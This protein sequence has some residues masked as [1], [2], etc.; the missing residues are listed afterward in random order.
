MTNKS[1]SKPRKPN[2]ASGIISRGEIKY[3]N[4]A[5]K[6]RNIRSLNIYISPPTEKNSELAWRNRVGRSQRY[7]NHWNKIEKKNTFKVKWMIDKSIKIINITFI[8]NKI[9]NFPTALYKKSV[10]A[11]QTKGDSARNFPKI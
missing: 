7:S 11:S 3:I 6:Q 1:S 5:K 9:R 8:Y 2:T 4:A 10:S